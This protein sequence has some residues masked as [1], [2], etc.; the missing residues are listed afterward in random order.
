MFAP[1]ARITRCKHRINVA[2]NQSNGFAALPF[3]EP[4]R[5]S[6][7]TRVASKR[8][9]ES[10]LTRRY[11]RSPRLIGER[12]VVCNLGTSRDHSRRNRSRKK[13][14]SLGFRNGASEFPS[15]FQPFGD[16]YFGVGKGFLPSGTIRC[17]ASQLRHLGYKRLIF[18]TPIEDDLVLCHSAS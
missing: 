13:K 7:A 4:A 2:A 3:V 1:W 8:S 5:C 11:R 12:W 9:S 10:P 14:P 17:A 18:V 16:H 6:C 15:G